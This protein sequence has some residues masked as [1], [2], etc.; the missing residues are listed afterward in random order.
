M[1]ELPEVQTV[2]NH[3]RD[4][5]IGETLTSV[6]PKWDK[7]L[8]NFTPSDID[9]KLDGNVII[10]VYRRAK[11]I[12]LQF[13]GIIIAIHLRMTG[14]L[15]ISL[16]SDYPKHCTAFIE[17][18]SGKKLIFED[19]RK[20]G[21][22]YLYNNLDPINYRH[23]PE[24][25]DNAF[26]VEK[27]QEM[28]LKKKRNIKALLLDQS[29]LSGLGNIYVDE[30]LWKS[31][32]HSNSISNAIPKNK[33]EALFYNIRTTLE[34]AIVKK[35]TTIIDFSVNGESG[36]YANMLQVFGRAGLECFQCGNIISKNKVAG[37]GTYT[38]QKCQKVY[39]GF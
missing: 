39:N 18:N 10:D 11:F 15:Y 20:F 4:D 9:K 6:V 8:H 23:G 22:F 26:T 25:L 21:R 34:E 33:V 32:I 2:V 14:K 1:P 37:R 13:N 36:K 35:G 31:K 7:V 24:P 12:I 3:I 27:F 5:L 38:C 28:L 19:V 16:D 30:S 17:F 29:F